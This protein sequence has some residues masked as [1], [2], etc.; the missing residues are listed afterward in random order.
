MELPAFELS[1]F[2]RFIRNLRDLPPILVV[3]DYIG[4]NAYAVVSK[5]ELRDDAVAL[6]RSFANVTSRE[7]LVR[8]THLLS[9]LEH[10]SIV[11][12]HGATWRGGAM[13][14]ARNDLCCVLEFM[15]DGNLEDY[16]R[17]HPSLPWFPV[18]LQWL[19]DIALGLAYLHR[20]GFIHHDL[21]PCNVLLRGDH[22]KLCQFGQCLHASEEFDEVATTA[23]YAAP[24][25]AVENCN[26]PESD[27]WSFGALLATMD[28]HMAS[29]LR[30]DEND[31]NDANDANDATMLTLKM[32]HALAEE[33]MTPAFAHLCPPEILSLAR[34]C[35]RMDP[36]CRP[37]ADELVARIETIA[38]EYNMVLKPLPMS[39]VAEKREAELRKVLPP[40]RRRY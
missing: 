38:D 23:T 26:L 33:H 6:K 39:A 21:E 7:H 13:D 28:R 35:L 34:D 12:C 9:G 4:R 40:R 1:T 19:Y 14:S 16:L 10:P 27:V 29:F 30:N 24:E 31:D 17:A 37:T 15:E 11:T 36:S 20:V 5:G 3:R 18:K 32:A 25:I 8:E 2:R 22:A